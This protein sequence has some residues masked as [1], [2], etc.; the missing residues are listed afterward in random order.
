MK[1]YKK[2]KKKVNLHNQFNT[3]KPHLGYLNAQYKIFWQM[4]LIY[5]LLRFIWIKK[6]L[7]SISIP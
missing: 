1:L 4:I 3:L 7:N 2:S 6:K 5:I